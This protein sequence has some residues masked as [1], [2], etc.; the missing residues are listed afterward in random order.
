MVTGLAQVRA[1]ASP[2][3]VG[4]TSGSLVGLGQRGQ[5]PYFEGLACSQKTDGQDRIRLS[6][7]QHVSGRHGQVQTHILQWGPS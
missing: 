5:R 6:K 1:Q 7:A 4:S 2:R 3:G